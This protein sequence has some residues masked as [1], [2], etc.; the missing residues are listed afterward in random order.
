MS[1]SNLCSY[2]PVVVIGD[3]SLLIKARTLSDYAL[4]EK[5]CQSYRVN[6]MPMI[7]RVVFSI[8][9]KTLQRSVALQAIKQLRFDCDITID[10]IQKWMNTYEGKM[11]C[12]WLAIRENGISF[13]ELIDLIEDEEQS[14]GSDIYKRLDYYMS[15]ASD[16]IEYS[17]LGS[18]TGL[19][20]S[21]DDTVKNRWF[22]YDSLVSALTKEPF[23]M[24]MSDIGSLTMAQISAII[25]DPKT[26]IGDDRDNET[27]I[28]GKKS[29]PNLRRS[30]KP[31]YDRG[32]DMIVDNLIAGKHLFSGLS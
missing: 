14:T 26:D 4:I 5:Q 30:K 18:I 32:Y 24:S 6:P 22:T 28:F 1:F 31:I 13:N 12:Y 8:S 27:V 23:S 17:N 3:R 7:R 21:E 19:F 9:D 15:I 20:R 25:R 2:G 11:F 29:D 10:V 16:E